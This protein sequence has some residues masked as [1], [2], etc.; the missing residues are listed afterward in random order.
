MPRARIRAA[1]TVTSLVALL[2]GVP[3]AAHAFPT[4]WEFPNS[5]NGETTLQNCIDFT[6]KPGDAVLIAT[7]TPISENISITKTLTLQGETGYHP[8]IAG[9]LSISTPAAAVSADVSSLTIEAQLAV[10]TSQFYGSTVNLHSLHLNGAVAQGGLSVVTGAPTST[11]SFTDSFVTGIANHVDAVKFNAQAGAGNSTFVADRN[12]ISAGGVTTTGQ[13]LEFVSSGSGTVSLDASDNTFYGMVACGGC[14]QGA[15]VIDPG[16]TTTDRVN[17]IGNTIDNVTYGSAFYQNQTF[18]GLGSGLTLNIFDNTFTHAAE[19]VVFSN[20]SIS[21]D[22]V[23]YGSND[24][25]ANSYPD[26]WFGSQLT[27]NFA[28]NPRYANETSGKLALK[29]ASPLID[30]GLVCTPAGVAIQDVRG[31]SRL[32]GPSVDVGAF[33]LGAIAPTG[34]VF[35]G[36]ALNDTLTGTSGNDILCG[37]AGDDTLDGSGGND[38]LDGGTGSDHLIGGTGSDLLFGG[39]NADMC[40]D[41]KDGVSGNDSIDGGKGTDAYSADAG[42]TLSS[43]EHAGCV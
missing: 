11:V 22:Q 40:L 16:G 39:A 9:S 6:A 30:K 4:I 12:R 35:L 21:K 38:Y 18:T 2:V 20:V 17:V 34:Q 27:P 26:V 3:T 15:L 36:T 37:F 29:A 42:D 25:Y 24:S 32:A 14:G 28:K 1:L 7:D 13:G 8:T 41:S 10:N 43:V 19:G 23:S 33:E 31:L 5:C